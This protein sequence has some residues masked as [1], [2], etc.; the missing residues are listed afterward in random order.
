MGE[1]SHFL[2]S[3]YVLCTLYWVSHLP[4]PQFCKEGVMGPLLQMTKGRLME[5]KQMAP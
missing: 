5:P 3:S 2:K 4:S 1:D